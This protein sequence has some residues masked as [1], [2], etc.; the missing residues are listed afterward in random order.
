MISAP[1]KESIIGIFNNTREFS[2]H[3]KRN[4]IEFDET[5]QNKFLDNILELKR[6]LNK[7][8]E[9]INEIVND[10]QKIT[11]V[12]SIANDEESLKIINDIISL[13]KDLHSTLVRQYV[14]LNGVRKRG[15]AKAESKNYKNAM[16][17]IKES[18]IDLESVF[19]HL[20]EMPEFI[21]TTKQLS[22]V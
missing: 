6:L 4:P 16:D 11:W 8:V 20:P 10:L 19:F 5:E 3:E 14:M 7:K 17:D 12:D 15:I 21:D 1:Q 13:L 2:Y 22:L 9:K 18:Y